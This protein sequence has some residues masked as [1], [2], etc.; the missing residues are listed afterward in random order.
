MTNQTKQFSHSEAR[1][2][3]TLIV[4]TSA[5]RAGD[6]DGV[7]QTVLT[8]A[9]SRT[10][11][12]GGGS[13]SSVRRR[14]ESAKLR[15]APLRDP[16][17]APPPVSHVAHVAPT[18][19]WNTSTRPAPQR[20]LVSNIAF[21]RTRALQDR[22]KTQRR[23]RRRH[24]RGST[25]GSGSLLLDSDGDDSDSS[26]SDDDGHSQPM[27]GRAMAVDTP[28]SRSMALL[29]PSGMGTLAQLWAADKPKTP[30]PKSLIRT[31]STGPASG[32]LGRNIQRSL[33]IST[34]QEQLEL[35]ASGVAQARKKH[36]ASDRA[37][38][39]SGRRRTLHQHQRQHQRQQQQQ[40]QQRRRHTTTASQGRRMSSVMRA[41]VA[42]KEDSGRRGSAVSSST[43]H[44]RPGT[45]PPI[46][47]QQHALTKSQGAWRSVDYLKR[48][49]PT[50][51]PHRALGARAVSR[52]M[53]LFLTPSQHQQ[54]DGASRGAEG[55]A[56]RGRDSLLSVERRQLAE[57]PRFTDHAKHRAH[58]DSRGARHRQQGGKQQQQQQ[59]RRQLP[60]Q[61][62]QASSGQ[63]VLTRSVHVASTATLPPASVVEGIE[64]KEEKEQ[65][66]EP[67]TVTYEVDL[68][69][70]A[71]RN[72]QV[73]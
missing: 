70:A 17:T 48:V 59:R 54:P 68:T 5:D 43:T 72:A 41:R 45:A 60:R 30:K 51:R 8:E 29:D 35:Y 10:A 37:R 56:A 69:G 63:P 53:E 20:Q 23:A 67:G 25:L 55:G 36:A 50:H 18:G 21:E 32:Q 24:K 12:G 2:Q 7:A 4:D 27:F 9:T 11:G 31:Y 39:S 16:A 6:E 19:Q 26:S 15:R 38:S 1:G 49:H 58:S 71:A 64:E 22:M 46:L 33:V 73:G 57:R 61:R 40:Q 66:L 13:S 28:E 47:P 65:S 34:E 52:H 42:A 14:R 62:R 3:V 44:T